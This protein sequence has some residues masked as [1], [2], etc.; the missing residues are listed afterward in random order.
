[1][2]VSLAHE[3]ETPP[4]QFWLCIVQNAKSSV[5]HGQCCCH[6]MSR[7]QNI[8]VIYTLLSQE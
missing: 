7:T 4:D 6:L 3:S 8:F 2:A 5:C 1:M